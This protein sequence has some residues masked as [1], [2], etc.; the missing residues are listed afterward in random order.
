METTSVANAPDTA[1][2][3]VVVDG[4]LLLDCTAEQAWPLILDYTKWQNYT[5]AEPVSGIRGAEGEVVLLKKEETGMTFPTYYARTILL[6]PGRRVIWKTYP[7]HPGPGNS[8]FGF[9]D[10][11]VSAAG[12]GARFRY[13][14]LYEL[15]VQFERPDELAAYR[16]TLVANTKAMHDVIFGRLK[17][18]AAQVGVRT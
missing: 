6:E 7:E 13:Q 9:V 16:E 18:L 11:S 17:H 2:V 12:A 4:D 1:P 3:Y 10:F 14:F 8:Y 15:Q 5:I